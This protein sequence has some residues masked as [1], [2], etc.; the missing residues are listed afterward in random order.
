M[1][2]GGESEV[3]AAQHEDPLVDPSIHIKARFN[4]E[5]SNLH[6]EK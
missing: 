4:S 2:E 3:L 1:G 5:F 6:A